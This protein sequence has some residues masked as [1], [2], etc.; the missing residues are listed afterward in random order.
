MNGRALLQAR[1]SNPAAGGHGKAELT[2]T[3]DILE[4]WAEGYMVGS[5][6]ILILIVA[7]NYR[8][9]VLLHK[10]ILLEVGVPRR[11]V[12]LGELLTTMPC[13]DVSGA[14]SRHV[15]LP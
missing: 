7:C 11:S 2:V 5:L 13:A 10:L 9:R 6:V 12:L 14:A 1:S 8:R 4:A 3:G 15:H